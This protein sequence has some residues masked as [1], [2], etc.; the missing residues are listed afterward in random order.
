M[1]EIRWHQR[2]G[3]VPAVTHVV[4]CTL[5]L[6]SAALPQ[7]LLLVGVKATRPL[8]EAV[9]VGALIPLRPV[10]QS[11]DFGRLQRT[12]RGLIVEA[13]AG[14]EGYGLGAGWGHG[15]QEPGVD[16]FFG[17]DIKT[18]LFRTRWSLRGEARDATYVGAEVGVT[19]ML[20]PIARISVGAAKRVSGVKEAD[21][22]IFTWSI[23]FNIVR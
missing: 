9:N 16:G 21:R 12:Y 20:L 19:T 2:R 17:A 15:T 23:G 5:A 3:V 8:H 14:S 10:E 11:D 6:P 4:F 13:S 7:P 1:D 18:T 22:T